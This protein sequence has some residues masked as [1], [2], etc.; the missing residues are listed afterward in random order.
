MRSI[1]FETG[2]KE[3]AIN[4]DESRVVRINTTDLGLVERTENVYK[5]FDEIFAPFKGEKATAEMFSK[6]DKKLREMLNEVFGSDVSTPL[7]GSINVLSPVGE[8]TLFQSAVGALMEIVKEEMGSAASEMLSKANAKAVTLKDLE[9]ERTE[10]YTAPKVAD[11]S[12]ADSLDLSVLSTDAKRR[13][14]EQL[15][16]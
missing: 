11:K 12:T 7:F 13:L 9:N 2:I 14:L 1:N 4:G 16:S 3:F 15:L 8:Q 10:K 6:A 5:N